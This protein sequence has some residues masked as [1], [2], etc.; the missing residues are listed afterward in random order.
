MKRSNERVYAI[1]FASVYPMYV[2][3]VE[4]KGR[5]KDEL[6]EVIRWLTGHSQSSLEQAIATRKPSWCDDTDTV[7]TDSRVISAIPLPAASFQTTYTDPAI[8]SHVSSTDPSA[9]VS[10]VTVRTHGSSP[11]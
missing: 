10:K 1:I 3:K 11:T 9:A 4:R 2:Q 6:D 7:S 5:T 8:S